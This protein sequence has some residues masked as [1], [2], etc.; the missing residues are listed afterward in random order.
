M[1]TVKLRSLEVVGIILTSPIQVQIRFQKGFE[2]KKDKKTRNIQSADVFENTTYILELSVLEQS[3][4][5]CTCICIDRFQ[6]L[7]C[8]RL[9][10]CLR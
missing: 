3:R 9:I 7:H 6:K 1:C 10:S 4:F 5:N 2:C 8:S